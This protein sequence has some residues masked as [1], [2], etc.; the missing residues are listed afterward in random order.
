MKAGGN[1]R[2][3]KRRMTWHLWYLQIHKKK[4]G[5]NKNRTNVLFHTL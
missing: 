5:E 4:W 1:Q 2:E 3:R